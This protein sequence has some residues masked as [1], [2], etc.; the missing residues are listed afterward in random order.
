M[1]VDRSV[2]TPGALIGFSRDFRAARNPRQTGGAIFGDRSRRPLAALPFHCSH[3]RPRRSVHAFVRQELEQIWPDIQAELR[4]AVGPSAYDLWLA[5]V[6]PV[7][8]EGAALVVS[9]PDE[10]RGWVADRFMRVLQTSVAAVV[11]PETTVEVVSASAAQS[12]P[13][14]GRPRHR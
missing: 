7:S 14:G 1:D 3:H 11:G 4:K 12:G 9:A 6:R 5:E 13:V 8:V 2:D 10:K